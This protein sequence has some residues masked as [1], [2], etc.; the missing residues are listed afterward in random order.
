[1]KKDLTK[2]V[3]EESS[4]EINASSQY[5]MIY[6][7]TKAIVRRKLTVLSDFNRKEYRFKNE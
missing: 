5:E 4:I 1:M 7:R 2:K 6:N 3:K